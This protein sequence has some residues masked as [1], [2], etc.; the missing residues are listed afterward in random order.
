MV[1]GGGEKKKKHVTLPE[2]VSTETRGVDTLMSQVFPINP[3]LSGDQMRA[4]GNKR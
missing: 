1:P 4:H 3:A 2:E